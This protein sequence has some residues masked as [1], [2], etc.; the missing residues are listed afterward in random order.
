[1]WNTLDGERPSA[2]P[3]VRRRGFLCTIGGLAAAG[4]LARSGA[5]LLVGAAQAADSPYPPA[6][7]ITLRRLDDPWLWRHG[8]ESDQWPHVQ[9]SRSRI[10]AC[11]GD[12]FGWN[13][14]P[15]ERKAFLGATTI[16]GTVTRPVA[17][18][19]W[20]DPSSPAI[21]QAKLK[22]C[23]LLKVGSGVVVYVTSDR[24]GRDGT[25]MLRASLDGRTFQL[26]GA[27]VL[28]RSVHGLQVV[29]AVHHAVGTPGDLIVLVAEHGNIRDTHLTIRNAKVW[30]ARVTPATLTNVTAWEWFCGHDPAGSP[31]WS[32]ASV[33]QAS[34]TTKNGLAVVPVFEDP[35]GGGK[36]TMISWCPSLNGYVLAKTHLST[37]LGLFFSR[38]P[39]GPWTA[40]YYNK[41]VD[42][43]SDGKSHMYTAQ[44]VT[45]WSQG[46]MLALRWGG[47][48]GVGK[49]ACAEPANFDAIFVTRF[50]VLRS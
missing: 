6:A 46:D 48:S 1:M 19:T 36:H 23:G 25:R 33:S 50:S 17:T 7:G 16:S 28:R 18:D 9:V 42:K 45:M 30:A 27:T 11:W 24:D 38:R 39:T 4:A 14:E 22:P 5:G 8:C 32:R 29:G 35:A 10:L 15:N 49:S 20:S 31:R 43:G 47:H 41:F 26:D 40:L 37:D 34:F 12:G 2:M 44:V 21:R 3:P 13:W